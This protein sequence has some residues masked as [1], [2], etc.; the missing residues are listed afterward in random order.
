MIGLYDWIYTHIK[1]V[2]TYIVSLADFEVLVFTQW[3]KHNL[4]KIMAFQFYWSEHGKQERES[5]HDNSVHTE[6]G[7]PQCVYTLSNNHI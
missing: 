2:E 3:F 1:N 6:T 7:M 5:T 4:V